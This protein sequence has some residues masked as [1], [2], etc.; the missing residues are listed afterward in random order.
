[1]KA[2]RLFTGAAV[3][4]NPDFGRKLHGQRAAGVR[5]GKH[6]PLL[7]VS[8]AALAILQ[9]QLVHQV[10][11]L[12]RQ[13]GRFGNQILPQPVSDGLADLRAG[14]TVDLLVFIDISVGHCISRLAF[15]SARSHQI[16]SGGA[17]LFPI[18]SIT[19]LL[20]KY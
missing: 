8:Q 13:N 7:K 1:L 4:R 18:S 2:C 20:G 16:K 6:I 14:R 11:K 12:G 19:C 5:C 10:L 17:E 9:S 3:K 15:I